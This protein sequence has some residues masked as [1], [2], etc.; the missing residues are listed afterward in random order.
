VIRR[1]IEIEDS[2]FRWSLEE[3]LVRDD[4]A[5]L[6]ASPLQRA[7]CR[8]VEGKPS[9]LEPA[10][11][12]KHF[13]V[14]ELPLGLIPTLVVLICGVRAGK[15]WLA[16]VAA[17][18]LS[19]MS[20]LTR[21]GVKLKVLELP[22]FAIVGPDTDT[23]EATFGVLSGIIEQ[24]PVLRRMLA[25]PPTSDTVM[26]KR[27]DGYRVE[28]TVVAAARGGRTVRNR[29]LAGFILEEVAQ[30][31]TDATGA[32]VN[33]EEMLRAARTRLLD[34]CQGWLI[35]SPYGPSG[36]L[37]EL[38]DKHFGK[39]GNVLVVHADT[40][41]MNPSFPQSVI[42]E[43][44]KDDPDAAAR[45]HG[46]EWVDA[47][48]AYFSTTL[49]V[50]AERPAPRIKP[51]RGSVKYWATGDFATRGNAW[52]WVVGCTENGRDIIMGAWEEVGS[53]KTPL[54][55]KAMCAQMAMTLAPYGVRQI[56]CDQWS[57]DAI[58]DHAKDANLILVEAKREN[59]VSGYAK[60]KSGLEASMV[61]LPP[62]PNVRTD[63]QGVRKRAKSGS[64][65]IVLEKQANG[66]HCDFAPSLALLAEALSGAVDYG[67]AIDQMDHFTTAQGPTARYGMGDQMGPVGKQ[68]GGFN[69]TPDDDG[70]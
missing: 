36:L 10:T 29:W 53:Q 14:D 50:A 7:I 35:S 11:N 30:I 66:R 25:A 63:L 31:G 64:L 57:F 47:D 38:W 26:L 62:V 37:Y 16:A 39:P 9:G 44:Q 40:R 58:N 45:E 60:L 3:T 15:S 49:I 6:D 2:S 13:G 51:A 67:E 33:A 22:R 43:L 17:I 8:V 12:R 59:V 46:A 20:P 27:P 32:A 28:I 18:Y 55:P 19:L 4:G 69:D 52:T 23:A 61:E 54:S 1:P 56:L 41:A 68:A 70:F 34:G 42:D 5:N 48:T 21:G 24:S 65:T